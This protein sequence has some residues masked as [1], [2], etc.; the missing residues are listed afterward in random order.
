[1]LETRLEDVNRGVSSTGVVIAAL[2]WTVFPLLW[3]TRRIKRL[4]P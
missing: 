3:F 1:L 4:V 2:A